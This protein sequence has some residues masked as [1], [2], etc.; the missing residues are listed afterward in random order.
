M[1]CNATATAHIV[2]HTRHTKA[3]KLRGRGQAGALQTNT[4]EP[5]GGLQQGRKKNLV[6][7][8]TVAGSEACPTSPTAQ[9]GLLLTTC[10]AQ[11]KREPDT[12]VRKQPKL[13]TATRQP[14]QRS[15]NKVRSGN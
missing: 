9:P 12:C 4:L 7:R 14:K 2:R 15:G 6:M 1:V 8:S 11:R 3:L 10:G 5:Q 13:K